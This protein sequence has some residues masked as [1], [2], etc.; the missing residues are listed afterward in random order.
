MLELSLIHIYAKYVSFKQDLDK[1]MHVMEQRV[2]NRKE[3]TLFLNTTVTPEMAEELKP[4][5]LV[6]AIGCLLYTSRCV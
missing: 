6:M 4:D 5:V 3:I 1:Y 2:L